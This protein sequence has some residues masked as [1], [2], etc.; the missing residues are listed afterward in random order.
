MFIFHSFFSVVYYFVLVYY[1]QSQYNP[2]KFEL[3]YQIGVKYHWSSGCWNIKVFST[4][5]KT[6]NKNRVS[7]TIILFHTQILTDKQ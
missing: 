5:S 4:V 7:T 2:L 1:I 6:N 3:F